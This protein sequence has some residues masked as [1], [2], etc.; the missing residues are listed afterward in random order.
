MAAT[1][2]SPKQ[3]ELRIELRWVEGGYEATAH[4]PNGEST[5]LRHALAVDRSKVDETLARLGRT[6]SKWIAR[7][8]EGAAFDPVRDLGE[9]LFLALIEGGLGA[10][11]YQAVAQATSATSRLGLCL[12]MSDRRLA[13]LPWELLYDLKRQDFVAL[14][15]RTPLVRRWAAEREGGEEAERPP[16]LEWPLRLLVVDASAGS[17]GA[18][19]E[20]D[21][22][23]KSEGEGLRVASVLE[24]ATKPR[25]LEAVARGTEPFLHVVGAQQEAPRDDD[26][27]RLGC[28]ADGDSPGLV[29]P[30]ELLEALRERR[31]AGLPALRFAFFSGAHTDTFARAVAPGLA[32]SAGVRD[33]L[34]S[35][36]A[37]AFA[38]GLYRALAEGR[39]LATAFTEARQRVDREAPGNRQWVL[40][41]LY[42]QRPA[43]LGGRAKGPVRGFASAPDVADRS[44]RLVQARVEVHQ[45][46]VEALRQA[47][48]KFE[49]G[50]RPAHLV[51]QLE[52]AERSAEEAAQPGGGAPAGRAAPDARPRFPL[53]GEEPLKR[54]LRASLRLQEQ[55]E[56]VSLLRH[57]TKPLRRS[58]GL[59]I[60]AGELALY[61]TLKGLYEEGRD[62]LRAMNEGKSDA[63]PH[64]AE[65]E[66]RL[67][68]AEWE[69]APELRALLE[70]KGKL[71]GELVEA[72]HRRHEEVGAALA[73]LDRALA[74]AR[75][76]MAPI[77]GESKR[78]RELEDLRRGVDRALRDAQFEA[79]PEPLGRLEAYVEKEQAGVLEGVRRKRDAAKAICRQ[80]DLLLL[81][82][83]LDGK[84]RRYHYTVLLRTPSEPGTQGVNIQ[85]STTLVEQDRLDILEDV[86]A[87]TGHL[88][89]EFERRRASREI[90]PPPVPLGDGRDPD[91]VVR[92]VGE[93]MYRL[94]M[95]EEMQRYIDETHC[96][97]T[98]TTNDLELPWELMLQRGGRRE[99]GRGDDD[100]FLCVQR[101]VARLPMGHA[102][103]RQ[104]RGVSPRRE[105]LRFLLIHSN[106]RDDLPEVEREVYAVR[107]ALLSGWGGRID[108]EVLGAA[109]VTGRRI[110]RV[111]REGAFDVIH[112]AGH[113]YSDEEQG[114][115][116]GLLL[117]G[118]EVFFAQKVRRLLEGRPLVFLNACQS[119]AVGGAKPGAYAQ[120]EG[121]AS[122]FI[123]GG[124]VA[125]IGSLW[126]IYDVP[127]AAFATAFYKYVLEGNM[128]GE[129]MRLA[130]CDV[131]RDH[132]GDATWAAFVLYGN[133][134]YRHTLG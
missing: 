108:V 59:V 10:R 126:P 123:Y 31:R 72:Y 116:S 11:Y 28:V 33:A 120:A 57:L 32:A 84:R 79:V 82:S 96:S 124:A 117:E 92:D 7:D 112:Y 19:L 119:G 47:L 46:N 5:E 133:P 48:A 56:H 42:L 62:R 113:A 101:P 8:A 35:A 71:H 131:R 1:N 65:L 110:N 69:L 76:V 9:R 37:G 41:V 102:F 18:R 64:L 121:L 26:D 45:R 99:G 50:E 49:G 118:N 80:A 74:E 100:G 94:L 4:W 104:D 86:K 106:P 66:R 95:P 114:D 125:C 122:A 73:E 98:V 2:D 22:L 81:R 14:S 40:P 17:S 87:F 24:A 129:A 91:E 75:Q 29:A 39:P 53:P 55:C 127:A 54:L 67:D 52:E 134:T 89:G 77:E 15:V 88:G 6:K 70:K 109:E 38:A 34:T 44:A 23:R 130:R 58:G 25:L 43:A 103:P 97:L 27:P 105:R 111:L 93:L 12:T 20:I 61:A 30:G 85:A 51:A 128:I 60:A 63:G 3:D 90:A 36:G 78:R 132:R 107:D 13:A 83:P 16:P 68:A 21:A 115:L